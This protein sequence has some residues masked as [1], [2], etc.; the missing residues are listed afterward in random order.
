MMLV[1]VG[2][3]LDFLRLNVLVALNF[4]LFL[5]NRRAQPSVLVIMH[6]LY[7]ALSCKLLSQ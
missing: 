4:S 2:S 7:T 1:H 3:V 6:I 5:S